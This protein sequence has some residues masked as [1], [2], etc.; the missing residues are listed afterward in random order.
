LAGERNTWIKGGLQSSNT[1]HEAC[2]G[3]IES[4][5]VREGKI[6][7]INNVSFERTD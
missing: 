2:E 6:G 1:A 4:K 7:H 3:E 5:T